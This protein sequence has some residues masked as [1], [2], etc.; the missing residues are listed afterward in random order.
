[1]NQVRPHRIK[2]HYTAAAVVLQSIAG[3]MSKKKSLG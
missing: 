2:F 3:K 1:M